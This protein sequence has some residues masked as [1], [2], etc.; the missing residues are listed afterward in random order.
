MYGTSNTQIKKAMTIIKDILK[1]NSEVTEDFRVNF[2]EFD[3]SS[4]RIEYTYFVK[5][6]DDYNLFLKTKSSINLAIKQ[7]FEKEKLHIPFPTQTVHV[8]PEKQ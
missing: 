7:A 1:A 4:L 6:P 2:T 3:D 8:Y 5:E